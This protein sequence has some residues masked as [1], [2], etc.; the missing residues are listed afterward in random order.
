M[1]Y[2]APTDVLD[3]KVFVSECYICAKQMDCFPG[4][5]VNDL[6]AGSWLPANSRN[7]FIIMGNSQFLQF[8]LS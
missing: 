6:A 5:W 3:I 1:S 2:T 8:L 4:Y 7:G